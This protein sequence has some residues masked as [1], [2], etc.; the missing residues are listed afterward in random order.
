MTKHN[1][2]LSP[3]PTLSPWELR[4]VGFV[5]LR[6]AG[7]PVSDLHHVERLEECIGNDTTQ[8]SVWYLTTYDT[9]H[10]QRRRAGHFHGIKF[11]GTKRFTPRLIQPINGEANTGPKLEISC[12]TQRTHAKVWIS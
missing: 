9:S 12:F 1:S 3:S 10:V 2:T 11:F 5:R 7:L 4:S 6:S 8:L